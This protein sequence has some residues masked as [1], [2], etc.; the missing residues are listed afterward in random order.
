MLKRYPKTIYHFTRAG[1]V[2]S[3]LRQGLKPSRD[4]L[5]NPPLVWTTRQPQFVGRRVTLEISTEGLDKRRLSQ[6]GKGIVYSSRIPPGNIKVLD[7]PG[8]G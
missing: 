6:V 1:N 4:R 8:R 3:I 7:R 2:R 5:G